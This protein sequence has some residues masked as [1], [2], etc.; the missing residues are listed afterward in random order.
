[1]STSTANREM[2]AGSR[3]ETIAD[4]FNN[5]VNNP[6]A[7]V[8]KQALNAIRQTSRATEVGGG[9]DL[10]AFFIN[11]DAIEL[12][13]AAAASAKPMEFDVIRI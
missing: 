3:G 4:L 1:M 8:R 6:D 2:Y 10:P 13:P 9:V 7:E 5:E 12:A 11:I